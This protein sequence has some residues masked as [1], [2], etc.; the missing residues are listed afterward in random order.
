MNLTNNIAVFSPK[1]S[2]D[3][4]TVNSFGLDNH[5]VKNLNMIVLIAYNGYFPY[6]NLRLSR[7][8]GSRLFKT[9]K[10]VFSTTRVGGFPEAAGTVE[11][12]SKEGRRQPMI[13]DP[14]NRFPLCY[15]AATKPHTNTV[16]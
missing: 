13:I 5:G 4:V 16:F 15:S 3:I 7:L 9:F 11:I 1:V 2:I 12:C 6:V 8:F 14:L 10:S